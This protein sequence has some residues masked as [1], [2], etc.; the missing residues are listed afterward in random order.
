M[1][2]HKSVAGCPVGGRERC[3]HARR[4]CVSG[5]RGSDARPKTCLWM[6]RGWGRAVAGRRGAARSP[7]AAW[8]SLRLAHTPTGPTTTTKFRSIPVRRLLDPRGCG[9]ATAGEPLDLQRESESGPPCAAAEH[10][11]IGAVHAELRG[12]GLACRAGG[13]DPPRKLGLA[14]ARSTSGPLRRCG[15]ESSFRGRSGAVNPCYSMQ[16]NYNDL[17]D[18]SP[19]FDTLPPVLTVEEVADLMRVDR[20]TAYAAIA[21]GGVPGVR[22]LGRCIRVSR[23][24]FVRWLEEGDTKGRAR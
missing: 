4:R 8:T 5:H 3:P 18:A 12:E 9:N 23:D 7:P 15:H 17:M 19:S 11:E 16:M 10:V 20:K 21:D 13:I 24:V 1:T 6:C 14:C 2:E 22:R